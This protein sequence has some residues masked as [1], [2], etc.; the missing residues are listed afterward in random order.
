[1]MVVKVDLKKAYDK[2][3]WEFVRETFKDIEF[4][5]HFINLVWHCMA[6][7]SMKV[8]INSELSQPFT[9]TCGICQGDPLSPYIFVLCM[10]RL[11]H[12]I[13]MAVQKQEWRRIA[14]SR[15]GPPISHVLCR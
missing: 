11:S 5:D 3:R 6:S 8:A 1:M 9:P 12:C 14:L 7:C 2:L 4:E 15:N 10:E 13:Q